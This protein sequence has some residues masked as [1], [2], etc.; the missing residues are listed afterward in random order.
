MPKAVEGANQV[1]LLVIDGLERGQGGAAVGRCARA[2]VQ[3]LGEEG[4]AVRG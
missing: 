4:V 2:A 1:V 3:E